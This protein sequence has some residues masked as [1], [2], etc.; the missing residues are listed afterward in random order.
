M[1]IDI[2]FAD[3]DQILKH[4]K[5][6]PARLKNRKHN[7]GIYAHRVPTDPFNGLCTVEHKEAEQI[8]WFKL[9]MLNV[10]IYKD[11][12]DETH[13]HELMEKEPIWDLLQHQEFADQVFHVSGH[14][15]LMSKLKPKNLQQLAAALAI[16][17]PSKRYLI[18]E[19]WE[20]IEQEVWIKPH[21]DRYYFKKAHAFS[22]AMAVVVHMNLICEKLGY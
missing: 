9:D 14:V 5:H 1:D 20:K 12:R 21:D 4:I 22:Y 11:V 17:R 6:I 7:T 2:D 3:R 8:G 13:L 16:I 10:S 19:S 18:N 15:D